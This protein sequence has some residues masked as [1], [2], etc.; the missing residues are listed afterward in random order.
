LR[1]NEPQ[2]RRC[3][4]KMSHAPGNIQLN[5]TSSIVERWL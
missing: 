3:A 1:R 2:G 5:D 4:R